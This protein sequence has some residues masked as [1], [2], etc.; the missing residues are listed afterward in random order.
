MADKP[1]IPKLEDSDKFAFFFALF[2]REV[3]F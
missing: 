3:F 2:S 1:F